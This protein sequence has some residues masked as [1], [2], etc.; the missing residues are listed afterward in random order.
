MREKNVAEAS[1]NPKSGKVVSIHRVAVKLGPTEELT[2]APFVTNFG[3]EGDWRSRKNRGRQITL[4]EAEVLT[5]LA[6]ALKL[7]AVPSGASRRQVVVQGLIL[8][9]TL[10]K[11]LRV[12]PLLVEVHDLCDPCSNMERMIAPGARALLDLSGGGVC[13]RVLEGG[14]LRPGDEVV[15]L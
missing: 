4:I 6:S 9:E 14:T 11:R 15:V 1:P 10:G 2:A 13:G 8:K 12:G 7:S 3:L 5:A